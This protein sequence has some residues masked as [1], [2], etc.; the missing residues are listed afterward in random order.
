MKQINIFG[1]AEA[2]NQEGRKYT[3]KVEAPVYEPKNRKPHELELYDRTKTARLIN[4]IE[5]SDIPEDVKTFLINAAHRH[6]VFHYE[7]IADYYAHSSPQVQRMMERSALVIIDFNK[8]IQHGYVR[9]CEDI[10]AQYME[11]YGEQ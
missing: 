11:E 8:A 5:A 9:L 1:E 10:R 3:G 7:R 2:E 6:T 4:E